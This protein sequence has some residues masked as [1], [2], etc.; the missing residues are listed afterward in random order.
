M[1]RVMLIVCYAI[2]V[3][4]QDPLILGL[5]LCLPLIPKII[6][7]EKGFL[8]NRRNPGNFQLFFYGK[9]KGLQ[10][11]T[12]LS[13]RGIKNNLRNCIGD[14]FLIRRSVGDAILR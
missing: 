8:K 12:I 13:L 2:M 5:V 9:Q 11:V 6:I 1:H 3:Q 4:K 14:S 7:I 10:S